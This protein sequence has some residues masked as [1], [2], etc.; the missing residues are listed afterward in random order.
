MEDVNTYIGQVQAL[1]KAVEDSPAPDLA[2]ADLEN[3]W[4]E[5]INAEAA[6]QAKDKAQTAAD[7]ARESIIEIVKGSSFPDD[8]GLT[9][10]QKAQIIAQI[11]DSIYEK[12]GDETEVSA[13]D[14]NISSF[15]EIRD[16]I[17]KEAEG[18]RNTLRDASAQ[19]VEPAVP[20]LEALI[21]EKTE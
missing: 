19:I 4:T 10:D 14:I 8:L 11:V 17:Q 2:A 21:S 7:D 5:R 9:D 3:G 1:Q 12:T 13:E 15:A 16:G 20:D 18:N 6:S